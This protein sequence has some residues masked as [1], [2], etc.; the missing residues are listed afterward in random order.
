M[1]M[2]CSWQWCRWFF[3]R[4]V[5]SPPRYRPGLPALGETSESWI[6]VFGLTSSRVE[7]KH[8]ILS[9]ALNEHLW[10]VHSCLFFQFHAVSWRTATFFAGRSG[11]VG[12]SEAPLRG[13]LMVS[14]PFPA[15]LGDWSMALSGR[16]LQWYSAATGRPVP[17]KQSDGFKMGSRWES[18]SHFWV[19]LFGRVELINFCFEPW[20]F[21]LWIPWTLCNGKVCEIM[22]RS[23]EYSPHK[24][25]HE[26]QEWSSCQQE[27][28]QGGTIFRIVLWVRQS[29]LAFFDSNGLRFRLKEPM[30]SWILSYRI[31]VVGMTIGLN[32][33]AVG[34]NSM[35][36]VCRAFFHHLWTCAISSYCSLPVPNSHWR[37]TNEQTT[38][39]I[40]LFINSQKL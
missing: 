14:D 17:N 33:M 36:I 3:L 16:W 13:C 35:E 26:T 9:M 15:V 5:V 20:S 39:Y 31:S 27:T 2:F 1:V 6:N 21:F 11:K 40:F 19:D 29:L 22:W 38:S 24:V 10:D 18:V 34:L 37:S 12:C 23:L 28:P 7:F 25:K 8:I 4:E 32:Q 30:Y